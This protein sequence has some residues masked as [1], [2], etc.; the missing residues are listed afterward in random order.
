MCGQLKYFGEN[1]VLSGNS[2]QIS[3]AEVHYGNG[4]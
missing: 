1:L 4:G 2:N 3:M